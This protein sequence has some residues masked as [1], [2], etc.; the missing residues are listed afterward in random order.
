[1][2][3]LVVYEPSGVILYMVPS[4]G[5]YKTLE[6]EVPEGKMLGRIEMSGEEWQPVFIDQPVTLNKKLE[7]ELEDAKAERNEIKESQRIMK[8][9][10]AEMM[11]SMAKGEEN[12][13]GE[14]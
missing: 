1:M 14:G 12:E 4:S 3:M 7:K 2:K 13:E 5:T 8:L 10:F 9:A 11:N 6:V